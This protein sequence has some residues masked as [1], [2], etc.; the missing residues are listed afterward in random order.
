SLAKDFKGFVLQFE[1]EI[2]SLCASEDF[3]V[4]MIALDLSS[5]L[6]IKGRLPPY[7]RSKLPLIYGLELPEIS[8]KKEAIP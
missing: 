4:R 2:S 6:E 7:E 3:S 8:N 1:Q 5:R